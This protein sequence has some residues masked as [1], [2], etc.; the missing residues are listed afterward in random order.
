MSPEY[1]ICCRDPLSLVFE[2]ED[3]LIDGGG[4]DEQYDFYR[5]AGIGVVNPR[6]GNADEYGP[7]DPRALVP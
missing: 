1:E 4:K 2:K 5:H 7:V 6:G 3:L